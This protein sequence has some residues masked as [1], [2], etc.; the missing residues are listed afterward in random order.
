MFEASFFTTL[1]TKQVV[2]ARDGTTP[3]RATA[4]GDVQYLLTAQPTRAL[5]RTTCCA[6]E[7]DPSVAKIYIYCITFIII[8]Y[9][10]FVLLLGRVF[11]EKSVFRP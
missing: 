5:E 1:L 2:G 4:A 11:S 9:P 10:Q 8:I 3:D 6:T 7:T